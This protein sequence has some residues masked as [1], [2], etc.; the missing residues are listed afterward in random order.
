MLNSRKCMEK[1]VTYLSIGEKVEG[2]QVK[3]AGATALGNHLNESWSK[4][5][6][7]KIDIKSLPHGSD[8]GFLV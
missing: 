5:K 2:G 7:T 4:L 8:T 6:A 3:L 1:M